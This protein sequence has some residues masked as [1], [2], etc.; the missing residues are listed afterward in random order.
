MR[1]FYFWVLFIN[2]GWPKYLSILKI[3]A[4]Q[5]R[6]TFWEFSNE[7]DT[8]GRQWLFSFL[9]IWIKLF[10]VFVLCWWK[11]L[12]IKLWYSSLNAKVKGTKNIDCIVKFSVGWKRKNVTKEPQTLESSP[13]SQVYT[14]TSVCAPNPLCFH[15]SLP[16]NIK[17]ALHNLSWYSWVCLSL[18]SRS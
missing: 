3:A 17:K 7:N 14:H 6:Q 11:H 4:R 2:A 1:D 13:D 10:L 9:S 12:Q 18:H 16:R 15:R 8:I 5:Y